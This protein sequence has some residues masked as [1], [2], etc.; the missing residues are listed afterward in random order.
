MSFEDEADRVKAS[1]YWV[2]ITRCECCLSRLEYCVSK[3]MP[4]TVFSEITRKREKQ[5]FK[6]CEHCEKHTLQTLVAFDSNIT[7]EQET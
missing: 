4:Y 1:G 3:S 5:Q 6:P 2:Y 7:D